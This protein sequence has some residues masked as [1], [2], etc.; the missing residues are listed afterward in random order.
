[1]AENWRGEC[2]NP[3]AKTLVPGKQDDSSKKNKKKKETGS[4]FEFCTVCNLNHDQGQRHKYFPSHK[5]SLSACLSRFESK[6]ADVRFF[7]RNPA[8]LRPEHASRN[9]FWCIFCDVDVEELGSSFACSNAIN[10]L[11]SVDHLKSLKHFMWKYGGGMDRLDSFR[12]LDADVTKWRKKCATLKKEAA[13]SEDRCHGPL[14][15]LSNDIHREPNIGIV[16]HFEDNY[17]VYPLKSS[18][19][20]GVTPLQYNTNEQQIL[21]PEIAGGPNAGS[22]PTKLVSSN[23]SLHSADDSNGVEGNVHSGA[24]PPWLDS[25]EHSLVDYNIKSFSVNVASHS[26]KLEKSRKLNPKRVG[27]AWAEKRKIEMELEKRGEIAKKECDSGWLPNFGRVWQSGSRKESRREFE[28]EKQTLLKK[29]TESEISK[30]I[31]PYISKRIVSSHQPFVM[32]GG[33]KL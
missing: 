31:Q 6:L 16:D 8:A 2:S 21:Y 28:M 1:M 24:A 25:S 4:Q 5:K 11:S 23:A 20:N 29:E 15:G 27:A 22:L 19:L 7:L 10:H 26:N 30:E 12:I 13:L 32:L 17:T 33:V 3:N 9:R 14:S 18:I